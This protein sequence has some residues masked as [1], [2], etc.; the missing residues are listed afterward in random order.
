MNLS[1]TRGANASDGAGGTGS[2][3]DII[4]NTNMS[5]IEADFGIN[6]TIIGGSAEDADGLNE[7]F[8][9]TYVDATGF[10][11]GGTTI[12]TNDG[13]SQTNLYQDQASN[14]GWE[15]LLLSDNTS[16]VFTAL[17]REDAD[18]YKTTSSETA[19]FQ[20]LV[21]ENGHTGSETTT[22]PYYFFVELT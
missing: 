2:P 5:E 20:M 6:N 11:V 16:L 21:L 17:I 12:D 10:N 15:E 13:C 14:T 7:T 4:Y 9:G 18:M 22:T 1:H 8:N 3:K 19:D